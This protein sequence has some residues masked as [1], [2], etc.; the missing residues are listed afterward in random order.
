MYTCNLILKKV[1]WLFCKLVMSGLIK[2]LEISK[3]RDL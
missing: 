2:D 1:T 3:L